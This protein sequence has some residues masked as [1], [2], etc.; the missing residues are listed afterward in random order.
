MLAKFK[1]IHSLDMSNFVVYSVLSNGYY[2]TSPKIAKSVAKTINS[3]SNSALLFGDNYLINFIGVEL[4]GMP[5]TLNT[6]GSW[7]FKIPAI[8]ENSEKYIENM[9]LVGEVYKKIIK[10]IQT[11]KRVNFINH[12]RFLLY[13]DGVELSNDYDLSDVNI[14]NIVVN[15][16]TVYV[17][18]NYVEGL[19]NG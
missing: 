16:L 11:K 9:N 19:E 7:S 6:D 10:P 12:T 8:D 5:Y 1:K 15:T 4:L 3:Y 2:W 14:L 18:Q 13:N 17:I